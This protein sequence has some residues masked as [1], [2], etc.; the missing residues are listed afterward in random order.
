VK[1]PSA[2]KEILAVS[3]PAEAAEWDL[4]VQQGFDASME[5]FFV[6]LNISQTLYL[7]VW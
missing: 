6:L 5:S 2:V 4:L 3:R 1:S 7:A